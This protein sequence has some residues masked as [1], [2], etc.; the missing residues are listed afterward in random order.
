MAKLIKMS[1]AVSLALHVMVLMASNPHAPLSTHDAASRI[2]VSEAH[3][4]K[5]LQR[6][7][8][9]GLV[10]SVRGPGGGF[11]LGRDAADISLLDVYESIEGRYEASRCLFDVAVCRGKRCILGGII[12]KVDEQLR[13]YLAGTKLAS[14]GGAGEWM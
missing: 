3:L 4:S 6:L 7:A 14:L 8:K 11:V 10:R 9:G 1:E 2:K 5:V 13:R 12:E